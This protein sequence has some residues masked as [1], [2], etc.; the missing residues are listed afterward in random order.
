MAYY[1]ICYYRQTGVVYRRFEFIIVTFLI[2][3]Q[4]LCHCFGGYD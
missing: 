4:I 2:W 3:L 1:A